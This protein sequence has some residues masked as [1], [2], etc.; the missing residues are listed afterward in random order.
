MDVLELRETHA[1]AAACPICGEVAEGPVAYRDHLADTHMLVDDEGTDTVEALAARPAARDASGAESGPPGGPPAAEGVEGAGDLVTPAAPNEDVAHTARAD[2]PQPTQPMAEPGRGGPPPA[3]VR[4]EPAR[5]RI[6]LPLPPAATEPFPLAL[7]YGDLAL[8][9][10]GFVMVVVAV[11]REDL[12]L[13]VV[14][15]LVIALAML[16]PLLHRLRP[17]GPE[18]PPERGAGPERPP[19]GTGE[20]VPSGAERHASG[21]S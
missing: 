8:Y 11:A 17:A 13:A 15:S 2:D 20:V 4:S 5:R 21:P 9:V 16:L 19:E 3:A 18:R 1:G 12:A 6:R 7:R 14:G 10:P